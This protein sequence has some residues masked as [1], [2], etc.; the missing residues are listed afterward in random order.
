MPSKKLHRFD[1]NQ[2]GMKVSI[3]VPPTLNLSACLVTKLCPT[4]LQPYGL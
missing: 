3:F 2:L 1:S 4:L